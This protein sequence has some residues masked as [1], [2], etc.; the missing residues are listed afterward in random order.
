[1]RYASESERKEGEDFPLFHLHTMPIF[2]K[3]FSTS[4]EVHLFSLASYS[5]PKRISMVQL[6]PTHGETRENAVETFTFM[7][8]TA[9]SLLQLGTKAMT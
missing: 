9:T 7:K 8:I 2:N 4:P 1:M 3:H 5:S 6:T